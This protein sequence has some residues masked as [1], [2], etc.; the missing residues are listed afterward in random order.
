MGEKG[1][2]THT[3]IPLGAHRGVI[4]V[5]DLCQVLPRHHA[6]A[7]GQPLAQQSQHC[8]PQQHPQQ[9]GGQEKGSTGWWWA[10]PRT[11]WGHQQ[12]GAHLKAGHGPALQV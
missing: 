4:E 7:D 6:Q 10:A 1:L 11:Q 8:G 12:P 3:V 2:L 9:L 5:A